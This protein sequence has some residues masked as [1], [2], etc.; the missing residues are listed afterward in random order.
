MT[1]PMTADWPAI[2]KNL[3]KTLEPGVFK[4]WISP[5]EGVVRETSVYLNAPTDFAASWIR[6]RLSSAICEAAA[7][8]L[9][10]GPEAISLVVCSENK[11][12]VRSIKHPDEPAPPS[13]PEQGGIPIKPAYP[14]LR[15]RF[16]FKDFVVGPNNAMAYAAAK[17]LCAELADAGTLFVSA[18]SGLGKTHLA[19]AVGRCLSE[20][21]PH[22][23]Y[24][25]SYLSA[26]EF[27]S[28]F[29]AALKARDWGCWGDFKDRLRQSD[30]LLLE[31]VHFLQNK[32]KMQEEALALIKSLQSKGSRM[33][34]TSS[35]A[36]RDLRHMDCQLVSL[37]CAGLL[38]HMGS[39][40]L[41]TRR[42]ILQKK[43]RVHQ[44]VL[45][46]SVSDLLATRI[47]SDVRQLESCLHKLIFMAR[48][49][50]CE[51]SLD[52]ALEMV[53]QYVQ[54][55]HGLDMADII[56]LVCDGFHLSESQITSRSRKS[57]YVQA[58]NTIY[59]LARKH[60]QLSLQE[61]G[62][63]FQRRH[64]SVIKGL[65]TFER[66]MQRKSARGSQLAH[67]VALV[68]RNAGIKSSVTASSVPISR[69]L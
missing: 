14:E 60:T 25:I 43:A 54:A 67:T 69:K 42:S 4:V 28:C 19:Q 23:C 16:S 8:V 34:L 48:Q 37:F 31:D 35:F 55:Q 59:Y 1:V 11:E 38:A 61:I 64:S 20:Q 52:M 9:G 26:E 6:E 13:H 32:G 66:E 47:T 51:I 17:G 36:P 58:R 30:V 22:K 50:K 44:V 2:V 49:L 12:P 41:E 68:E 53:G 40:S 10:L 18:A 56:R 65:S 62:D 3:Q 5:L 39:P 63:R 29:V 27:A 21:E 57:E 24:K 46:E 15:W 45:P 7:E 33:V